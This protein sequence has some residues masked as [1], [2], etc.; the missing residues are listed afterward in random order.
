MSGGK[1]PLAAG[2]L[3]HVDAGKTTLSEA[4]LF[5][6]G[7][8][9][10]LGRVDHGD[11]FLDTHSLEKERG[12]TIFSKEARFTVGETEVTLLDTPGHVDFS[13]EMER[14]LQVL[15]LAILVISGTD[16]VQSHTRT[17]WRLCK[18][19]GL[20]V[21]IFVNKMDLA[22]AERE[23]VL[24]E[25]RAKLDEGCADFTAPRNAAFYDALAMQDEGILNDVL[26][27]GEAGEE[28]VRAAIAA[29]HVFPC[30]FGSALKLEGVDELLTAL[31]HLAPRPRYGKDF[32]A[33]VYKIGKD[34]QGGR[35]TYMK[36][37]GGSLRVKT[38]LSGTD[39]S[40]EPWS[41]KADQLRLY[42]GGKF[43]AVE[44][45]SAGEVC[46]VCGLSA[47]W[48]GEGLGAEPDSPAPELEAVFTYT[49]LLPDTVDPHRA[50][51]RLRELEEEAPELRVVW[52]E[53]RQRIRLQLMGEVQLEVLRRL[54]EER[55]GFTAAFSEGG[56]A[57]RET[58]KYPVEGV[59][60][61]E[62]LRHYAEVHLLLEPGEPGSGL[63]FAA[64]VSEDELDR[65]WQRLILTHLMEKQHRGVLIGAPITDMKLTLIAGRAHLKHTEGGDF[66]QATYRAV[67]QGLRSAESVLLEPW[68]RFELELP[69]ENLGRA[70]A[71]VQQMGGS[72]E[73]AQYEGESAVLTGRA[74]V[75]RLRGYGAELTA[76]SHGL[77]RLSCAPD[78]YA[79]CQDAEAVVAAVGYD[80]D[81]DLEN[82][83]D[84][85]FCSHGAGVVVKWNEVRQ[86]MHIDTGWGREAP[87]EDEERW[88]RG[89]EAYVS[90]LA[91]DEER[92]RIFERTYGPIKKDLRA[93]R[94]R[95]PRREP[96]GA[97]Y[98]ARP[99]PDG[100]EY[101]LVDGY[102]IIFAWD[103]LREIAQDSLDAARN[104]LIHLMCN[105]QGFRRCELILVF[106]AYKVKGNHGSVERVH[107]VSVVYTKEAETADMYIEKVTKEIGK[108]H[109]VRVA[110]SDGLEQLIIIGHGAL[111]VSATEFHEEV[112]RAEK[113][114]RDFLDSQP[115]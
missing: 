95:P 23:R 104:R 50:L 45:V 16:G 115:L 71:D 62:P 35:L 20:P 76:Y 59:G 108:R 77:G 55:F 97:G 6:A 28:A 93:F 101:L 47:T 66:R 111:R 1:R 41:E 67:R 65:N 24:A 88:Q 17:L 103:E 78:G 106:D 89:A 85:V 36:L 22:G 8:L 84:S 105:Y 34:A 13:A 99:L 80:P 79:P 57:Y 100:P 82:S 107:N 27:R 15:D 25:L 38:L 32:A 4:L 51:D 87:E 29:R 64:A 19:A 75:A 110:T 46:A 21:F 39:R 68:Y 112:T 91:G 26:A 12:I 113:A 98:R 44:E 11:A 70:I 33:K 81:G 86:H 53:P 43:R 48:P 14:T 94:S 30:W 102:N 42:S 92:L 109:R 63:R 40:G 2:I 61:Y 37:T 10:S 52:D 31:D 73:P 96:S 9:R 114:I 7:A 83:A 69:R 54:I 72:F 60:H 56:I 18:R 90:R 74:P 58:I 49:L 3:A 5:R